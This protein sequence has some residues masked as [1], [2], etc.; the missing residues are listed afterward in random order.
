ML[1]LK[2][3]KLGLNNVVCEVIDKQPNYSQATVDFTLLDTRFIS[4]STAFSDCGCC[5]EYPKLRERHAEP[6]RAI[7]VHLLCRGGRREQRRDGGEYDF[8]IGDW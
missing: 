6:A 5:C 2:V 7:H 3:G 8:L 4:L 1:D